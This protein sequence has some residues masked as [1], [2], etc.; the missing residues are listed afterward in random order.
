[1]VRIEKDK[2]I[3]EIKTSI[4][5]EELSRLTESLLI[6][7]SCMNEDNVHLDSV[8]HIVQLLR[9]LQPTTQQL[10]LIHEQSIKDTNDGRNQTNHSRT[11]KD[12]P[13]SFFKDRI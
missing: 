1:M 2:L 10:Q 4:G 5:A 12:R 7:L 9:E 11:N 6:L 8:Y 13:D 3:I